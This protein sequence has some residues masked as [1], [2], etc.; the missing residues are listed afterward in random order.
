M[1]GHARSLSLTF[2]HALSSILNIAPRNNTHRLQTLYYVLFGETVLFFSVELESLTLLFSEPARPDCAVAAAGQA[3][4]H[5][6]LVR[7]PDG[8]N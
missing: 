6:G 2:T 7:E 8:G 1:S 3:G 5:D 4:A